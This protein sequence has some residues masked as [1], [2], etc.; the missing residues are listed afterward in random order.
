MS[1]VRRLRTLSR[2]LSLA[3]P[4]LCA[5]RDVGLDESG[6]HR[7]RDY[8]RSKVHA[9]SWPDAITIVARANKICLLDVYPGSE[10]GLDPERSLFR[11]FSM[12]KPII[13]VAAM[14]LAERGQLSLDAPISRYLPE[15]ADR[16]WVVLPLL[17]E[18]PR[19]TPRPAASAPTVKHLLQHTAGLMPL[20]FQR[21]VS[22]AVNAPGYAE[23]APTGR[24]RR[25]C[26]ALAEQPLLHEPGEDFMYAIQYDVLGRLLECAGG[27]PLDELLEQLVFAPVGMA[28]TFFTVPT[29]LRPQLRR[30][31]APGTAAAQQPPPAGSVAAELQAAGYTIAKLVEMGYSAR[32]LLEAGYGAARLRAEGGFSPSALREAGC[33][34]AE[35]SVLEDVSEETGAFKAFTE[36]GMGYFSGSEGLVSSAMD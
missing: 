23:D 7:L 30:C 17:T 32:E 11:I 8:V 18:G 33:G 22:A 2:H 5:A 34:A 27:A 31:Y 26:E 3:P 1:A 25:V 12:T 13:A 24:L 4:T 29:A 36:A 28:H 20:D 35:L 10:T 19:A 9:G 21:T 6:V 16:P 14:A 15:F